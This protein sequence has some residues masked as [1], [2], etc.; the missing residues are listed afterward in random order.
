[1]G[2]AKD[3]LQKT[4]K[5]AGQAVSGAENLA[6]GTP[7]VHTTTVAPHKPP[8]APNVTDWKSE[9]KPALTSVVDRVERWTWPVLQSVLLI[10]VAFALSE[11]TVAAGRHSPHYRGG[12]IDSASYA[13]RVLRDT[14][15]QWMMGVALLIGA[16]VLSI[17]L[18][19]FFK[20]FAET[21][22]DHVDNGNLPTLQIILC[23]IC[24]LACCGRATCL[25]HQA[26]RSGGITVLL[27]SGGE[28]G[29]RE[30]LRPI[31]QFSDQSESDMERAEDGTEASSPS[32]CCMGIV[33]VFEAILTSVERPVAAWA[34]GNSCKS[35]F[36]VRILLGLLPWSYMA[37]K[38]FFYTPSSP[39]E[40]MI[41]VAFVA[42]LI[43]G[44][45]VMAKRKQV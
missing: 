31:K 28:P 21:V 24:L 15:S 14:Y 25:S 12:H 37:P 23:F 11:I 36:A 7:D 2:A 39:Y 20:D 1:M 29:S 32:L 10:S 13:F 34:L 26:V 22:Q 5:A 18:A 35:F 33:A 4:Q 38:I 45:L 44:M 27:G 41:P 42:F 8:K 6:A 19:P 43:G 30:E 17:I 9:V 16:W 3:G 40:L